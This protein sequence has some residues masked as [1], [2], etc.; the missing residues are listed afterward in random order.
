MKHLRENHRELWDW[1]IKLENEPEIINA[2][3]NNLIKR[4]MS[5]NEE[6]FFWED[7]QMSIFDF[8]EC[9]PESMKSTKG[10]NE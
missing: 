5:E 8:P 10:T 2:H 3:W 1:I 6:M 7:A 4:K 9:V